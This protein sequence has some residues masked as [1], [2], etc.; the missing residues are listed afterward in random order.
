MC[1]RQCYHHLV[2][3]LLFL[4]H[5]L[6]ASI[7]YSVFLLRFIASLARSAVP[8]R[9]LAVKRELLSS[10]VKFPPLSGSVSVNN[11]GNIAA[12]H[13]SWLGLVPVA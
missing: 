9:E 12:R 2:L 10:A 3:L 1:Y 4:L 5:V 11:L 8:V 6:L 13:G 7:M